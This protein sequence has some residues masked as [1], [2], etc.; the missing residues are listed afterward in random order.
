DV[1]PLGARSELPV[2]RQRAVH[3]HDRII[4]HSVQRLSERE[5]G[6]VEGQRRDGSRQPV[7]HRCGVAVAEVAVLGLRVEQRLLLDLSGVRRQRRGRRSLGTGAEADG[8]RH[9]GTDRGDGGRGPRDSGPPALTAAMGSLGHLL[10]TMP[11]ISFEQVSCAFSKSGSPAI[12]PSIMMRPPSGSGKFSTPLSRMHCAILRAFS[13]ICGSGP[14]PL[15][16]P[17]GAYC[18]HAFC[19]ACILAR[20]ISWPG[21]PTLMLTWPSPST[22]GSSMGT[23]LSRMHAANLSACSCGLIEA[24]TDG[25][26]LA[27]ALPPALA[28]PL[29]VFSLAQPASTSTTLSGAVAAR[30]AIRN[31]TKHL[32]SYRI[33]TGCRTGPDERAVFGSPRFAGISQW[34]NSQE[35]TSPVTM[36]RTAPTIGRVGMRI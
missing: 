35:T 16:S 3:Q 32:L 31:L 24:W 22:S 11:G 26:A 4:V 7:R 17:K 28:T 10:F 25:A 13:S 23:P 29:P 5:D 18:S 2:R 33:R 30:P 12:E 14:A 34:A 19:A 6:T 9:G 15:R 8:G 27:D 36:R 20:S 21:P 1:R